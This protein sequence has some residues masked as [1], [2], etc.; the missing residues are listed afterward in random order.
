[1]E[2]FLGM[3]VGIVATILVSKFVTKA[4]T[5]G[6]LKLNLCDPEA[7]LIGLHIDSKLN[8]LVRNKFVILKIDSQK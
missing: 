2:W 1:M 8:D 3:I 7:E 4:W 5:I 6:V